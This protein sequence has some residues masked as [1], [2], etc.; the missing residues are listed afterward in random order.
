MNCTQCGASIP[1]NS[2]FC[3]ECG[4]RQER[5][6][7]ACGTALAPAAK[8]CPECGRKVASGPQPTQASA[9]ITSPI[10]LAPSPLGLAPCAVA[11]E[12]LAARPPD[13]DGDMYFTARY[14]VRND[15]STSWDLLS[16]R[17]HLLGSEGQVIK[18]T[19]ETHEQTIDA[20]DYAA[21]E[22]NW[23]CV[24][25]E[26][27]G[28]DPGAA[29]V[30]VDVLACRRIDSE[31]GILPIPDRHFAIGRLQPAVVGDTLRIVSGSIFRSEPDDD[32]QCPVEVKLLVQNLTD[33][34]LPRVRL[35][36]EIVDADGDAIDT[37]RA[38]ADLAPSLVGQMSCSS[39]VEAERLEDAE[40]R[41]NAVAFV[42]VAAGSTNEARV[43]SIE[44]DDA[45]ADAGDDD[46]EDSDAEDIDDEEDSDSEHDDDDEEE[47]KEERTDSGQSARTP[48]PW[49]ENRPGFYLITLHSAAGG[50]FAYGSVTEPDAI[51]L[52]KEK[53]A[54]DDLGLDSNY[55]EA[56]IDEEQE[57][58]FRNSNDVLHAYGPLAGDLWDM[59]VNLHLYSDPECSELIEELRYDER[60]PYFNDFS[61]HTCE[62]YFPKENPPESLF[63]GGCYIEKR[64][65]TSWVIEIGE[66]ETFDSRHVW[67]LTVQLD[68]LFPFV[69]VLP[70]MMFYVRP[71][72]AREILQAYYAGDLPTVLSEEER[73]DLFLEALSECSKYF[74]Y[75]LWQEGGGASEAPKALR[76]EFEGNPAARRVC[77]ILERCSCREHESAGKGEREE[78]Y[79]VVKTM[80]GDTLFEGECRP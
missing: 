15:T 35:E 28:P 11:I 21:F 72:D 52:I 50:E 10:H 64:V 39:Y 23:W 12:G 22:A 78:A 49:I 33:R 62:E 45:E 68:D 18:T 63:F 29:R 13:S 73:Y 66:N 54:G 65:Y 17:A 74:Y 20:G 4:A 9:A 71:D 79:A 70:M 53:I 60:C 6:C 77:E 43:V 1:E 57:F 76:A 59:R 48:D 2:K 75:R 7:A 38:E 19:Q 34:H 41:V 32:D 61:M 36:A 40:I 5:K 42:A 80:A 67:V 58:D 3:P 26:L 25:Q 8:F 27:L 56:D 46:D 24:R 30:V 37:D 47:S 55:A 44:M 14:T 51:A 69:D 16:V 31:I